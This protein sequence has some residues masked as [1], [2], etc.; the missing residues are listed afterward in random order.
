MFKIFRVGE[1]EVQTVK[2]LYKE[3]KAEKIDF[4]PYYQRYG[5]LWGNEKNRLL[6]DT[7]INDFDI[8]KF[9][10]NYFTEENNELNINNRLYAIID[11]KQRLRAIFDF[12][13]N[14]YSL[15]ENIKFYK[16]TTFDLRNKSYSDLSIEFPEI[17]AKID[18][19]ILDVVFVITN[20]E[21]KLEELFTRLNGG[22][23]L[24][25]AE[26]RNAIGGYMNEKIRRIVTENVF[27]TEK[28]RF[29]NLRFQHND[30]LTRLLFLENT[31]EFISM[32]NSRLDKF[33]RENNVENEINKA[34]LFETL[35]NIELLN[36]IFIPADPLLRNKGIVPVYY[37]FITR[38]KPKVEKTRDFLIKFE[39][40]RL[41]NRSEGIISAILSEFDRWNQQ[42]VHSEKSLTNRYKILQRYYSKYVEDGEQLSLA[43][44]INIEDIENE[45]EE[46]D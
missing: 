43:D 22:I 35:E 2:K 44:A 12:L 33:M 36:S 4:S 1:L 40:L 38:D 28:I 42:A 16:N 41:L 6:I 13:D 27:F 7:I 21:E 29:K 14:K 15:S 45:E 10:L 37:Y 34:T 26:K 32:T 24:T 30:L 18:N 39:Q 20:D 46:E 23:A 8:P 3:H 19:Y 9:Y 31:K 11:G 5:K 17:S 25:N